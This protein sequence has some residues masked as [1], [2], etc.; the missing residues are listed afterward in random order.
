MYGRIRPSIR[1]AQMD[2]DFQ[3][4]IKRSILSKISGAV[5]GRFWMW[6]RSVD[7]WCI[8]CLIRSMVLVTDTLCWR[9]VTHSDWPQNSP[10]PNRY[11][12]KSRITP[13]DLILALTRISTTYFE[14]LL[15]FIERHYSLD[16]GMVSKILN[17]LVKLRQINHNL[18]HRK[19]LQD[20]YE[21]A[22]GMFLTISKGLRYFTAVNHLRGGQELR[23]GPNFDPVKYVKE[24]S[25]VK[26]MHADSLFIHPNF[27]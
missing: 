14:L 9:H 18:W 17:I 27:S 16:R 19:E 20:T 25:H 2:P 24:V 22:L 1:A 15:R 26:N 11:R 23:G 6:S 7:L 3:V 21:N 12:Y 13:E 10:Y 5:P 8:F 4:R